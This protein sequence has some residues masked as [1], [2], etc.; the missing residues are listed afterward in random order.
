[1]AGPLQQVRHEQF[2]LLVFSGMSQSDAYRKVYP[3][4]RKWQDQAVHVRASELH[5]KVA[6][7]VAELHAA[8][9]DKVSMNRDQL[10]AYL[11]RVIETPVDDV[12]GKSKLAQEVKEVVRGDV[13]Y[14]QIKMPA[15]LQAADLLC[16]ILGWYA[17]EKHEHDGKFQFAPDSTVFQAMQR[18]AGKS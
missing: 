9:A 16:K 4:S 15:K 12:T 3:R 14:R 17:P 18:A 8:A 5:R 1:M 2:A 6:V 11:V 10:V 7:R 13:V